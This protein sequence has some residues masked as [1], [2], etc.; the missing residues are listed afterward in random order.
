MSDQKTI[1]EA[2]LHGGPVKECRRVNLE[3]GLANPNS[4]YGTRYI[5]IVDLNYVPAGLSAKDLRPMS[6]AK[7]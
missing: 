1:L 6:R 4:V 7:I 2:I 3:K 5:N